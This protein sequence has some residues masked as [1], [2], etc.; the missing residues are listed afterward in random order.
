MRQIAEQ[1]IRQRQP[2]FLFVTN[3]FEGDAPST[4][5][6]V[7]ERIAVRASEVKAQ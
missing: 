7:V 1:S 2:A 3:R 5:E 6:A 4:I